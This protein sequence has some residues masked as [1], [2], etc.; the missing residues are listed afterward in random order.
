LVGADAYIT[1]GIAMAKLAEVLL[2]FER[3]EGQCLCVAGTAATSKRKNMAR[4]GTLTLCEARV[5]ELLS[6]GLTQKEVA[7]QL[8]CSLRNVQNLVASARRR[9]RAITLGHLIRLW[10]EQNGGVQKHTYARPR[11]C[12]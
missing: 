11:A 12:W 5:V 8:G 3:C 10:I 2:R 6:L 7:A 9:M 4:G 1:K